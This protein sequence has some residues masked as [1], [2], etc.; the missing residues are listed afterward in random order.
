[1]FIMDVPNIP[2]QEQPLMMVDATATQS[3]VQ[4][5]DRTIGVCHLSESPFVPK[6]AVNSLSPALA[7]KNYYRE[8]EHY[9]IEGQPRVSVLQIPAHGELKDGGEGHY[10]Y[11]P[12]KGYIG[13]D[14]ATLLVEVSGKKVRMEYF[15]RVM[16]SIPQEYEG[17]PS[18][19]ERSNCP[20]KV[21][22]WKISSTTDANGN[23]FIT[24]VDIQSPIANA[25]GI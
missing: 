14:R 12:A 25:V 5:F 23:N 17:L 7:V 3:S 11:L 22:V 15:F 6:S 10:A 18:V 8:Q 19:E 4:K 1:M 9:T 24:A 20:K 13:N 21:P 16:Q 2:A